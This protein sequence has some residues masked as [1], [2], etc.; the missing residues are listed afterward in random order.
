MHSDLFVLL[1]TLRQKCLSCSFLFGILLTLTLT[2]A[3]EPSG[4]IDSHG[5]VFVVVRPGLTYGF[6]DRGSIKILLSFFLEKTFG[7]Y[8]SPLFENVPYQGRYM[9]E[10][11]IFGGLVPL[12]K[13]NSANKSLK[14]VGENILARPSGIF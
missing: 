12:I 11:K 6:I 4:N 1:P 7:V 5:K 2:L 10:N 13:I 8:P 3:V 9:D 14:G